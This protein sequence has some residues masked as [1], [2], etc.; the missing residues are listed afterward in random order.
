MDLFVP[1]ESKEPNKLILCTLSET[2]RFLEV[3]IKGRRRFEALRDFTVDGA[4]AEL[5]RLAMERKDAGES[6]GVRTPSSRGGSLEYSR[7]NSISSRGL[8]DVPED[9][10]FALDDDEDEGVEDGDAD[11]DD[12]ENPELYSVYSKSSLTHTAEVG[13]DAS[14]SLPIQAQARNLSEKARGKRPIGA[15]DRDFSTNSRASLSSRNASDASLP[16]LNHAVSHTHTHIHAPLREEKFTPTYEWVST[17]TPSCS[18]AQS[19]GSV[20]VAVAAKLAA[21]LPSFQLQETHN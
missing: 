9:S 12:G 21:T 7:G 13:V 14:D 3:I 18:M 1:S 17:S 6:A 11:V 8:G 5:D 19:T 16:S 10:A 15:G 20:V 2:G 4:L